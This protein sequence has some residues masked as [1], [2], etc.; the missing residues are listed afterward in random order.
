MSKLHYEILDPKREAAFRQLLPFAKKGTLGGGTAVALHLGH[1]VSYDFDIFFPQL[2]G[3][4]LLRQ[5]HQLFP[6]SKIQLEIDTAEELTLLLDK[7]IKLSFVYFPFPG[8][9]SPLPTYSLPIFSLK[10]LAANKAYAIGRRGSWR[11]Y[12]DLHFILAAGA[13]NLKEVVSLAEKKFKGNFSAKLFLEQLTYFGDI[14]D[15]TIDFVGQPVSP[16]IIKA[17]LQ[18]QA[19]E[20][21]QKLLTRGRSDKGG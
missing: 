5:V 7:E 9:F 10:D 4:G 8:L 20:F 21:T 11:D 16:E 19:K 3:K 12:V 17:N 14:S 15:Y 2:L 13:T 18:K 6:K 1:R